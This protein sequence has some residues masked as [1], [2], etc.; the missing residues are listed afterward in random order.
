MFT[1]W[2]RR[3]QLHDLTLVT[4]VPARALGVLAPKY[5]VV[6]FIEAV[7]RWPSLRPLDF[8]ADHDALRSAAS[9]A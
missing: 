4:D 1:A 2:L 8:A 7:C 5:F 3:N 9:N 6:R